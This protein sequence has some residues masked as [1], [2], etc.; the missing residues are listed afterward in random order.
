M[1]KAV[2]TPKQ[3]TPNESPYYVWTKMGCPFS[4]ACT[5]THRNLLGRGGLEQNVCAVRLLG[6]LA[7]LETHIL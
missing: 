6:R 2:E 7:V 3:G 5:T 1:A 4:V